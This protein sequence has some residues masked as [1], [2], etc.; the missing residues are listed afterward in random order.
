MHVHTHRHMPSLTSLIQT[1]TCTPPT[2]QPPPPH[3]HTPSLPSLI[4]VSVDVFSVLV[5]WSRNL[6]P[7]GKCADGTTTVSLDEAT[8]RKVVANPWVWHQSK[9]WEIN[10][11]T[12]Y[13]SNCC[14]VVVFLFVFHSVQNNY[15]AILTLYKNCQ[16]LFVWW[17]VLNQ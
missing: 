7:G 4:P 8:Q 11:L 17:N 2:P 5:F 14:S 15:P 10:Q 3:T 13:I 1:Q 12:D 16:S 9:D 6:L